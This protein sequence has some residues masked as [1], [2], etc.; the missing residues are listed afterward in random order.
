MIDFSAYRLGMGREGVAL[1]PHFPLW[2][3]AFRRFESAFS[4]RLAGSGIE[5]HH[6]GSTSI[7]GI[8]AKPILD[9][10]GVVDDI[11]LFDSYKPSVENAGFR[12]KGEH[13]IP[14][15]RY[16]V[17]YDAE[18]KRG[19][20]HLHVFERKHPEVASHLFFRDCLRGDPQLAREYG[21][22]KESLEIKFAGERA[23]YTEAKAEFIQGVLA[24]R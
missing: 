19:F 15:R 8:K 22:L 2:L 5:L 20:V 21:F 16:S 23:K 1:S 11:E 17:L 9:V 14:G 12:W 3:E 7:P 10:M 4:P 18:E 24:K 13:G 6:I